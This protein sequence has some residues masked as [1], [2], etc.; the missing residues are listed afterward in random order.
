MSAVGFTQVQELLRQLP[1]T[2]LP[3]AYR[4][5]SHLVDRDVDA[6]SLQVQ[7]M[8]LPV[9]ERRRLMAQ[10]AEDTIAHY[11]LSAHEREA[12]Q[13]GDFNDADSSG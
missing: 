12:W 8:R 11:A 7:A 4:L 1:T 10:Q 3:L 2:K 6:A 13:A 9:A 5:L